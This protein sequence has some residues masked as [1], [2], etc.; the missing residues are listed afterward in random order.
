MVDGVLVVLTL[1]KRLTNSPE[2]EVV[3]QYIPE[4]TL[5]DYAVHSIWTN[6]DQFVN[7]LF[8]D[9][10]DSML[11][12]HS[13]RDC[14][15]LLDNYQPLLD[16]ISDEVRYAIKALRRDKDNRRFMPMYFTIN[17]RA[18]TLSFKLIERDPEDF[19]DD[20]EE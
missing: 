5:V 9:V 11:D 8:Q 12:D 1:S 3:T 16:L 15:L 13:E 18:E 6:D 2:W 20:E 19:D 7:D 4:E 10:C 14:A 17:E